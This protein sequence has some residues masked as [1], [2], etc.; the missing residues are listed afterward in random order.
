MN[1]RQALEKLKISSQPANA[2]DM[3][4]YTNAHHKTRQ[5]TPLDSP[6]PVNP[7][8]VTCYTTRRVTLTAMG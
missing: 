2:P 7:V 8:K 5:N 1:I 6:H 4:L 3:L